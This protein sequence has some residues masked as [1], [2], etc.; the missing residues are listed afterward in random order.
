FGFFPVWDDSLY[1][2]NRLAVTD[3]PAASWT[4]RILT[5][6]LGYPVPLPTLLYYLFRQ[7][8]PA[9]VVPAVHLLSLGFHL[10]N[11]LLLY[12][13]AARWRGAPG[14]KA[15]KPVGLSNKSCGGCAPAFFAALLWAMHPFLVESVAWATNLKVVTLSTFLLGA[16]AVWERHLVH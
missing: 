2:L 1:L 11:V 10:V 7:L 9:W 5:P 4:Q 3:W 13:I 6:E 15:D 8:P 16:L 12:Q 14:R